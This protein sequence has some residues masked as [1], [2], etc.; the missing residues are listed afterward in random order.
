MGK[1]SIRRS[2]ALAAVAMY[3]MAGSHGSVRAEGSKECSDVEYK[4]EF[5]VNEE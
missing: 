4:R 5:N 3:V 2:V 1:F